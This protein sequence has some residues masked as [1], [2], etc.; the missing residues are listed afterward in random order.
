MITN[1]FSIFDPSSSPNLRLN[2]LSIISV[3]F[4]IP[5]NFWIISSRY[6]IFW[7]IIFFKIFEEI[8][9]NLSLKFQ[10]FIPIYISIFFSILI[11]NCL[12]LIPYVFTPSRHIILS[13]II[14]FPFWITLILKG[15]ITS[16][17]KIIT[18][19]VPLGSPII[20]TF[21]IVIIETI[22]NLIR[23]ITLSIR[24]SANIIRGH[25]LIHL[26][27][28]IPLSYPFRILI[29]LPIIL[30]LII[31]ETAVAI[32]QRYVFITLSSLYTNEI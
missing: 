18:H 30:F 4:I 8:K 5:A 16:F 22:R 1:L 6:Q 27:T 7:K 9:N 20:L 11:F 13:I 2:W 19:L 21:F 31:L 32:I 3:L 28:S 12:G 25:L 29:I 26:L 24:L 14:A 17:N 23:P 10:K 15:W